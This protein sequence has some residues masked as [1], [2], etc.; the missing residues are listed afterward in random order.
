MEAVPLLVQNKL[1]GADDI[2][3]EKERL[4]Y[5]I[6]LR[7]EEPTLEAYDRISVE[8]FGKGALLGMGWKPGAPIGLSNP[9]YGNAQSLDI[10]LVCVALLRCWCSECL[11]NPLCLV[12]R[13]VCIT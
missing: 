1:P 9:T 8:N 10:Y 4:M 5:D 2:E 13:V 11:T 6:Q 12:L 3:D 7:P